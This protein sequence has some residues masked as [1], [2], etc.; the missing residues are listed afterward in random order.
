MNALFRQSA[1]FVNATAD[2]MYKYVCV[3]VPY[4]CSMYAC[5]DGWMDVCAV[6]AVSRG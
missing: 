6:A 1:T 5:M 2:G 3:Y 4:V